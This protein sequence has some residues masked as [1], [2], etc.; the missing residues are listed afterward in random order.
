MAVQA[1]HTKQTEEVARPRHT[2]T[3]LMGVLRVFVG[4][5][6]PFV[7][8]FVADRFGDV[9]YRFA[10]KSR[11]AAISNM[12]H[13]M[14]N[15]SKSDLKNAVHW[16]FRN[17]MRNYYDLCRA[18]DMKDAEID[19]T[20]DF[21]EVGWERLM[22]HHNAGRGVVLVT[23]H[24]GAFDMITQVISRRGVPVTFLVAQVKPAW[25]SDFITDL[26]GARGMGLLLVDQEEGGGLNLGALKRSIELLRKGEV[27]GV[28]GDRNTEAR[29]IRLPFFG[30]DTLV[31]PGVAK[32]ALRTRSVVVPGFCHRM[33][34]NRYK[35]EFEA[36]IEPAGS[37]SN[38]EDVK[39]LLRR[40]FGCFEAHIGRNPDQ[41][42]LLQPVWERKK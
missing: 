14:G 17:V 21:D 5:I 1:Q 33:K 34:G 30:H 2:R 6:P 3:R 36:P 27:L 18:P 19:R 29:G 7:G 10:G 31:A 9:V 38:E 37:A 39:A 20:V 24:F 25:L 23:A 42:V 35:V 13:V 22:A 12:S 4:R 41:W 40:I 15:A 28:V 11:R 8:N 16:V 32:I 26:R